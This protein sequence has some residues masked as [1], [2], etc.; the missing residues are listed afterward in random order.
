MFW[1]AFHSVMSAKDQPLP[2][3]P[4]ASVAAFDNTNAP[5]R[6]EALPL[7]VEL[8]HCFGASI[9]QRYAGLRPVQF[10][11][12]EAAVKHLPAVS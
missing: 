5:V 6:A 7:A 2:P 10:K 1:T 4:Q 11:D 3:S 8:Y 12:F 9:T